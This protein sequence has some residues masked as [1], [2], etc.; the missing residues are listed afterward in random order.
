LSFRPPALPP[1]FLPFL[2][3]RLSPEGYLGLHLTIGALLLL[4]ATAVFGAIAEDVVTAAPI[5]LLDVRIAHW[6]HG[7]ANPA[8]TRFMLAVTYLHGVGGIAVLSVLLGLVL[9]QR[10]AR[11]WLLT[12]AIAVAGG[13]VLN[14]AMKYTFHRARPSFDDPLLTLLTYS[15]PS[16]HTAGSTAFYGVLA[17]YLY[18]QVHGWTARIGIILAALCMVLLVGASRMYLGVHY[19]SDVL[20]AM[21]EGAAWLALTITAVSTLRR[22]RLFRAAMHAGAVHG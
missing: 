17:S 12:L 13:A 14:V 8:L 1:A 5:T 10:H 9:W 21:A 4:A 15:F 22:H 6:L 11:Y 19:F 20:G 16:G 7:H 18:A 2:R 3:A